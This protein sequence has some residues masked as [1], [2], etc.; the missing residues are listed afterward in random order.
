MLHPLKLGIHPSKSNML[1]KIIDKK[2]LFAESIRI[3]NLF[4]FYIVF[5]RHLKLSFSSKKEKSP[6]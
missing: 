5:N 2:S 3:S 1:D 4:F 6:G